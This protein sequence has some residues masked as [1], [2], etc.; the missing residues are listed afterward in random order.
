[1]D[2]IYRQPQFGEDWFTYPGLYSEMVCRF[3]SGSRFAELGCHRGKSTA[4]LAVEIANSGKRIEL[5]C[6]DIWLDMTQRDAFIANMAP[7]AEY[8]TQALHMSTMEA[9]RLFPD[10]FF[11]FVFVDA[12]HSY[13]A[14]RDDITHWLPKVRRGGV[15]AGHDYWARAPSTWPG[16]VQAVHETLPMDRVKLSEECYIYEKP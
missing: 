15:L 9:V 4:Y 10:E 13:E 5:H 12:F 1:M 16:V 8:Y 7:L 3:P 14:V 11:D 6:V 2:H